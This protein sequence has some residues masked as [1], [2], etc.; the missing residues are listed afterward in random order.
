MQ[1]VPENIEMMDIDIHRHIDGHHS[2]PS[3]LQSSTRSPLPT[4]PQRAATIT[5]SLHPQ[6]EDHTSATTPPSRHSSS[7]TYPHPGSV[8]HV[9]HR[10]QRRPTQHSSDYS[11]S[12]GSSN[13]SN[14]PLRP[15]P[16]QR[17]NPPTLRVNTT[18]HANTTATTLSTRRERRS[19]PVVPAI[20]TRNPGADIE[21]SASASVSASQDQGQGQ[22]N[23]NGPDADG[24]KPKG[25]FTR[26]WHWFL[27]MWFGWE[28]GEVYYGPPRYRVI[29]Q[30]ER[31][32]RERE[33]ALLR[34]QG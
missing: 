14:T 19:Y 4:L 10:L 23:G 17:P 30:R 31:E 18:M 7:S 22:G 2:A 29:S 3:R 8:I 25:M 32:E 11:S 12:S 24:K 9:P 26:W 33:R 1:P 15:I 5:P 21:A 16:S 20:S 13:N 28:D 34:R 27:E 6:G